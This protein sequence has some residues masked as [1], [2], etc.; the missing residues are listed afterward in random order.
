MSKPLHIGVFGPYHSRNFG[1]TAIQK[2]VI[3]KLRHC[4]PG[5]RFTAICSDPPDAEQMHSIPAFPISGIPDHLTHSNCAARSF[6]QRVRG[7]LGRIYQSK[8]GWLWNIASCCRSLDVLIISGSGQLDDFWGGPWKHPLSMFVWSLLAR[9]SG[10]KVIVFGIGWDDLST[11]IG[12]LFAFNAMRLAHY[13]VF[14]DS[15]TLEKLAA[16][17]VTIKNNVCPDPAFGLPTPAVERVTNDPLIVMVCPIN[18]RA[19]L[20]KPDESY[21]LYLQ[22]LTNCCEQLLRDGYV[23]RLASSQTYMDLPLAQEM[24]ETLRQRTGKTERIQIFEAQTVAYFQEVAR[25]A[26]VVVASRLHSLILSAVA[27]TPL[28][29]ISYG[30]KVTHMMADLGMSDFCLELPKLQHD[31]LLSAVMQALDRRE[32]LH[33]SLKETMSRYDGELDEQYRAIQQIVLAGIDKNN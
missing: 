1:D 14:R 26:D 23:I 6:L 32:E 17:G 21:A 25:G 12:K 10:K 28:V 15:G 29:A 11:R 5:V 9:L 8:I 20:E 31:S 19:W 24:A 7:K 2:A 18:S 4:F 27:E 16:A 22:T 30:R 3:G 33:K 13:R